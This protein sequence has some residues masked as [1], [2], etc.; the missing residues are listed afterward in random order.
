MSMSTMTAHSST[1]IRRKITTGLS[2]L[3]V[4]QFQVDPL[5]LAVAERK[6]CRATLDLIEELRIGSFPIFEVIHRHRE[7]PRVC[8]QRP[9]AELPLLVRA[10]RLD[11]ACR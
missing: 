9:D 11:E 3:P 8:R 4:D 5:R 10:R 6:R 7:I 2:A 1:S